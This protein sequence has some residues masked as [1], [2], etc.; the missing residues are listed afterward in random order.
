MKNINA[1][2][3]ADRG[4]IL[5]YLRENPYENF[6]AVVRVIRKAFKDWK[7]V[8]VPVNKDLISYL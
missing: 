6:N 8:N 2:T 4:K 3:A 1:S 7:E 5:I